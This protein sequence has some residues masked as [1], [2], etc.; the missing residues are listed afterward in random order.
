MK[1]RENGSWLGVMTAAKVTIADDHPAPDAAELAG[2]HDPDDQQEDQQDGEL[3]RDPERRDHERDQRE[4]L[5]GGDERL[6]PD[7]AGAEQELER[8][9]H[10]HHATTPPSANRTR[11]AMRKTTP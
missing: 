6:D 9:R 5:V 11:I 1:N 3:E 10:R 4:V 7:A 8:L 2:A